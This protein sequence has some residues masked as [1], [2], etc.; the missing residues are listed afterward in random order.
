MIQH[1]QDAFAINRYFHGADLFLT[2]TANPNWPE[3]KEALLPGQSAADHPDLV[4]HVYRAKV[5]ELKKD[6]FKNGFLGQAVARVWTTE[7][8]KRGLPHIH[9]II[10]LIPAD[11]L[12]TPEDIDTLLSAEFPDEDEEPELLEL[13]K[14]FMVHTPCGPENSN[15]P[16][17]K[18]S[19]CSKGFPK[20]FRE[21]TTINEDSYANLRRRNTGKRYQVGDHEV[22]NH[23]VVPYPHFLALEVPL[24]YQHGVHPFNQ[25]HQVHLQI[26][27]QRP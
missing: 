1:C 6:I 5:E 24:S 20:P 11:K 14:K 15:A 2:M 13:V 8:Q 9:M 23:W 27:L 12:H 19:K 3:I 22:D 16:C 7:F 26:C 10:F 17:M 25:G 21:E 4:V 18:N